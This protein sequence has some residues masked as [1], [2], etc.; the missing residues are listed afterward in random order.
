LHIS[1]FK[2]ISPVIAKLAGTGYYVAI[3]INA[4]PI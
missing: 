1:P 3:E 2:E 4:V